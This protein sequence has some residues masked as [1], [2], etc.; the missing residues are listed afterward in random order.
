MKKLNVLFGMWV[1]LLVFGLPVIGCASTPSG[2]ASAQSGGNVDKPAITWTLV[3]QNKT[4]G[5]FESVAYGNGRFI[6]VGRDST[7]GG[8]PCMAY[9]TDGITWTD[10][11][12]KMP[13]DTAFQTFE[14]IT[15][16][17][18]KF[19][20][21]GW[22][23]TI[24]S[25]TDGESWT[26]VVSNLREDI[27]IAYGNGKYV[28]ATF[29]SRIFYST[30]GVTWTLAA[31]RPS[32]FRYKQIVYG[33]GKFVALDYGNR[34]SYSADGVTWTVVPGTYGGI[35]GGIVFGDSKFVAFDL[36]II[37]YSTDGLTWTAVSL[38]EF[39]DWYCHNAAYGAG[40]FVAEANNQGR[41]TY[42]ADGI[43]WTQVKFDIFA[44][45]KVDGI[46]YGNG[47][48]VLVGRIWD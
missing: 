27:S 48:F 46:A 9:S 38:S 28:F 41:M 33:N 16:C 3:A 42:S 37:F 30:D 45:S 31:N 2:D 24:A 11:T 17:G 12:N 1:L 22:P 35:L 14:H 4:P 19:F 36:G 40:K 32:G 21:S 6:A 20:I 18:S 15:F 29:D 25:S 7:G 13:K 44:G 8:G 47:R 39:S 43:T 34:M 23:G 10:I 26:V 5:Y